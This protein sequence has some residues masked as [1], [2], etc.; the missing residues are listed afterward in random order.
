MEIVADVPA[1]IDFFFYVYFNASVPLP[2]FGNWQ[3]MDMHGMLYQ[4][5]P[6]PCDY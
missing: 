6:P 2:S 4:L 3:V 5:E 1:C